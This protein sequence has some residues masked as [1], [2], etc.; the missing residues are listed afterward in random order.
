MA[1]PDR[2]RPLTWVYDP[3]CCELTQSLVA[4]VTLDGVPQSSGTLAIFVGNQVRGLM[5]TPLPNPLGSGS[6]FTP[7]DPCLRAERVRAPTAWP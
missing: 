6:V 1:A 4:E 2:T 3:A 7:D 5:A